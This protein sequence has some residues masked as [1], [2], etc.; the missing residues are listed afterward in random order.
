MASPH[1]EIGNCRVCQD[2]PVRIGPRSYYC[3]NAVGTHKKCSFFLPK[4][5]RSRLITESAARQLIGR[6][7]TDLIKGFFSK[8][9]EPFSA[10]LVINGDGWE[11]DFPP[12]REKKKQ[13]KGGSGDMTS[14]IARSKASTRFKGPSESRLAQMV[15]RGRKG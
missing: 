15:K 4:E 14:E 3:S 7:R 5:I 2:A 12:R 9:G 6:G 1:P 10:Y 13:T 8:W 11:F